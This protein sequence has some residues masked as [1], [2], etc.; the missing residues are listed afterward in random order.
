MMERNVREADNIA[1]SSSCH[2]LEASTNKRDA[3]DQGFRDFLEYK[4]FC[5]NVRANWAN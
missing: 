1:N 2:M 4:T 5:A 3:V